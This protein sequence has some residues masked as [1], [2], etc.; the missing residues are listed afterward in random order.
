M[1]LKILE[2]AIEDLQRGRQFY[3]RHGESVGEYF[4]DSIFSDIDSL[5]LYA[6]IHQI[7][8]GYHRLHSIRVSSAAGEAISLCRVLFG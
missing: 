8:F 1:K 2:S 5:L 7:V 6:G 3:A 4:M